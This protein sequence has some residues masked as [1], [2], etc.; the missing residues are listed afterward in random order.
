MQVFYFKLNQYF[1]N[2]Y[3]YTEKETPNGGVGLLFK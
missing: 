3:L 1:K 2:I